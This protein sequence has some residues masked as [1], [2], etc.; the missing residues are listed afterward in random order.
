MTD[1]IES[2][3]EQAKALL[4]AMPEAAPFLGDWP[5]L[6]AR[7]AAA[8]SVL[9]VLTWLDL[10]PAGACPAT[11]AL[12]DTIVAAAPTLA[13]RQTYGP[14]DFGSA[15]LERYGYSEVIGLRGP[16]PS[17]RIACGVLLLGPEVLYPAHSHAAEEVY[18]P[19]SGDGRVAAR[20]GPLAAHPAGPRHPPPALAG[21]CDANG[22]RAAPGPLCLARRRPCGKI[23][24]R[25]RALEEC[26]RLRPQACLK[27]LSGAGTLSSWAA[28]VG[29]AM[30]IWLDPWCHMPTATPRNFTSPASSFSSSGAPESTGAMTQSWEIRLPPAS[31]AQDAAI[32]VGGHQIGPVAREA[33]DH[34]ILVLAAGGSVL[35]FKGRI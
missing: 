17:T 13:W 27:G 8:P 18:L 4:D 6:G 24:H 2:L 11:A 25:T 23:R 1:P 19:L 33:G 30:P 26:R 5:D 28:V 22:I 16:V 12:V 7:R 31:R 15:F 10:L 20:R 3:L 35:G 14:Q 21:A 32:V 34:V 29:A 9:P